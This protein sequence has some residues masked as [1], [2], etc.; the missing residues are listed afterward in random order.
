MKNIQ[1]YTIR[2]N[3][4]SDGAIIRSDGSF[5]DSYDKDFYVTIS[6][7]KD[8]SIS[9]Y[10]DVEIDPLELVVNR[11]LFNPYFI[12]LGFFKNIRKLSYGEVKTKFDKSVQGKAEDYG[13][14]IIK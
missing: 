14:T 12:E 5:A 11:P 7:F 6:I 3:K 8:M 13:I 1:K 9:N 10:V 4:M 2:L